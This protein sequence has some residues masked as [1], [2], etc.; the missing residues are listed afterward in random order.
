MI[1]LFSKPRVDLRLPRDE[2]EQEPIVDISIRI[3]PWWSLK[4]YFAATELV[5]LPPMIKTGAS[6]S[7]SAS[8][9]LLTPV[10]AG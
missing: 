8:L 2:V 6:A 7:R 10:S 5:S 3:V 1:Q 4:A 9:V